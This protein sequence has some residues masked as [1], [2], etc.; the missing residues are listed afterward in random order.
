M[1]ALLTP[2]RLIYS[3]VAATAFSLMPPWA[4]RIYGLPGLPSTDLSASL[5]VRA[6]RTMLNALP[7][8]YF[9]GPIYKSAMA[10]VGR[11]MSIDS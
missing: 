10:R 11:A 3:G 5:S 8:R 6:L 9:E 4:R 1:A 7:R 2:A